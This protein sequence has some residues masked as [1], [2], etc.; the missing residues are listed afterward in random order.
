MNNGDFH[1]LPTYVLGNDHLSLEILRDAGPRIVRLTPAGSDVNL[2]AEVPG[3][4]LPSPH[5]PY[6]LY[7]GHR[8]WHAPEAPLRTYVPDDRGATVHVT[9]RGA[10]MHMPADAHSH[11]SKTIDVELPANSATVRLRHTVHNE[12]AWPVELA[13][14]AITQLPPDGVAILPQR[15]TP[16]DEAGLLPNRQLTLWPYTR[17]SDARLECYEEY[18]LVRGRADMPEHFKIGYMNHHNWAAHLGRG[19]LFC[20][21]TEPQ[22]HRAHP[23]MGCNTEVYTD[24]AFLELETLSPLTRLEP[25]A[26]LHHEEIWQ[27]RPAPHIPLNIDGIRELLNSNQPQ[28]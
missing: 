22:P 27:I 4:T 17:W 15:S 10:R 26:Q 2:L 6:T 5:G 14:W 7:G 25:G 1:G 12:G 13:A 20:K 11:I 24:D 28:T 3:V 23:D 16:L 9:P 19:Y 8:L 18:I 21:V